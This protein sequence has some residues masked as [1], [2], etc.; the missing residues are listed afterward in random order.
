MSGKP[1][2]WGQKL[3]SKD[4]ELM[5]QGDTPI[6][7]PIS[8]AGE[9]AL[10]GLNQN[11]SEMVTQRI[12][13]K[14]NGRMV[15]R[16]IVVRPADQMSLT[17]TLFFNNNF[18]TPA[19]ARARSSRRAVGTTLYAVN[20]CPTDPKTKH[21]YI[22]PDGIMNPPARVNDAVTINETTMA[23]WQTEIR[24]SE[25]VLLREIGAFK[26]KG[27]G[28]ALYAVAYMSEECQTATSS[29][30]Y[31]D[32]VAVG[33]A[34]GVGDEVLVLVTSNRFATTTAKT[35]LPSPA[36]T[37]GTSVYTNGNVV[38]I[39]FSDKAKSTYGSGASSDPA[40][41][42][43]LFSAD[44]LETTPAVDANITPSIMAVGEFG[45]QYLAAGGAGLGAAYLARSTDGVNWTQ[46]TSGAL[47]ADEA[48]TDFAVDALAGKLYLVTEAGSLLLGQESGGTLVITDITASLPAGATALYTAKAFGK[49][50]IAVGGA[51]NYYAETVDGVTWTSPAV[52]GSAA[53]FDIE[54]TAHRS[55][56]ATGSR[57]YVRDV[58]TGFNYTAVANQNGATFGTFSG[59]AMAEYNH[60]LAVTATGEA[61]SVT[62]FSPYDI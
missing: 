10:T 20:L 39:G 36:G 42:G 19:L 8:L 44:A 7:A 13:V 15:D 28:S 57:V 9:H 5:M 59:L 1:V 3:T 29:T 58:M 40:T 46:V 47:P 61:A 35:S 22:F 17:A 24:F 60:Y 51:G 56:L 2:S 50:H 38:L 41:G 33:G 4:Y 43:V 37:V 14:I 62:H 6:S 11:L 18:E 25:E 53:I 21:A 16:E 52:P 45:G 55:V 27:T 23:E 48:I 26:N 30:M 34:G 12:T 32:A 54:G 49:N 31:S